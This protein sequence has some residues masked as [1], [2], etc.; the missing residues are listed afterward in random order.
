MY[1]VSAPHLYISQLLLFI[2][3]II[4]IQ[5]IRAKKILLYR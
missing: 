3:I 4:F 2:I 5:R 1:Q